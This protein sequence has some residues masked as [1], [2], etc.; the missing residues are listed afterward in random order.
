V[1]FRRAGAVFELVY[2]ALRERLADQTPGNERHGAGRVMA[3]IGSH[4]A[5]LTAQAGA[6]IAEPNPLAAD[7]PDAAKPAGAQP[8]QLPERR[9]RLV[10]DSPSGARADQRPLGLGFGGYGT[11]SVA[12]NRPPGDS[13]STDAANLPTPSVATLR[14]P[15]PIYASLRT[16]GQLFAGF[17]T[18]ESD[19]ALILVDQHA[20]HERVTF[21]RLRHQLRDGGIQT[22]ALLTPAPLELNPARASQIMASLAELRALGF[23]LEPFGPSTLI[24]K[25]GPAVFGP[26]AGL[27]LL[28]DMLDSMGDSGL[29]RRGDHAFEDILKQLACHGSIRAGRNLRHDE[30]VALL[31]ELDQ[32]EFKTN[33]PHGRPVHISFPR[34]QIE[35]MFRR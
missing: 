8:Y 17:I 35:R 30:I 6:A 13:I 29:G 16:I 21:E 1:R 27:K 7:Q 14:P 24:V 18:L 10:A 25:G 4:A 5:G 2:H 33:C 23:G 3:P 22:Q 12:G 28:A 26:E 19:D 32:T 20:A 31:A 34:G 11:G 9:L 15:I